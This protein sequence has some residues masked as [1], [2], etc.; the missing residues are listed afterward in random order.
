MKTKLILLMLLATVVYGQDTLKF[1]GTGLKYPSNLIH[2][3]PPTYSMPNWLNMDVSIGEIKVRGW[4][5]KEYFKDLTANPDT[6]WET[7][8]PYQ[9]TIKE[10]E[11]FRESVKNCIKRI[12]KP[13]D[14]EPDW[15]GYL[16]PRKPTEQDFIKWYLKQKEV[17]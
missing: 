13:N 10:M 5:A 8:R 9:T 2:S 3:S 12:Y 4:M 16:T 14:Y 7:T 17:Q 1:S 6:I 15:I 11:E